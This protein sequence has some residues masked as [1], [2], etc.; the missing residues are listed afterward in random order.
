MKFCKDC[1]YSKAAPY[2][3]ERYLCTHEISTTKI[4]VGNLVVGI[5]ERLAYNSCGR[6]RITNCSEEGELFEE[7]E[8]LVYK[9]IKFF[10][11]VK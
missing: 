5:K 11:K 2:T 8:D 9:V 1:K 6:M 7:R 10:K 4:I 3:G